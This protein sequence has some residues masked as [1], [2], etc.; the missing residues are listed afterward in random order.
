M[1]RLASEVHPR[2]ARYATF[3]DMGPGDELERRKAERR[4]DEKLNALDRGVL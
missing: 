1:F 4:L 3:V 2:L